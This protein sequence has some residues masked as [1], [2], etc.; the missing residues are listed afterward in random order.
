MVGKVMNY[1]L[2]LIHGDP[3]SAPRLSQKRDDGPPWKL[4]GSLK[5]VTDHGD[6]WYEVPIDLGEGKVKAED[7]TLTV[8]APMTIYRLALHGNMENWVTRA[9]HPEPFWEYELGRTLSPNVNE[10]VLIA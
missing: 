10:G 6:Y 9:T 2:R 3:V 1:A 8:V 7:L 4:V 5:V